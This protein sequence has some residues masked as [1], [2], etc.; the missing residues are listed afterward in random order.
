MVVQ[1]LECIWAAMLRAAPGI[2]SNGPTRQLVVDLLSDVFF[3]LDEVTDDGLIME[4]DEGKVQSRIYMR[5]EAEG[6]GE[7]DAAAQ[8]VPQST[9]SKFLTSFI[10]R[11][12]GR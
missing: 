9:K 7:A 3:F 1:V 4:T 10:G 8:S 12:V 11:A 5:D 2:L 6:G